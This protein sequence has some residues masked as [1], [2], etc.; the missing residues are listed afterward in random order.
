MNQMIRIPL[1][2][3]LLWAGSALAESA[4]FPFSFWK[5]SASP[6]PT[7]TATAT[8]TPTATATATSTPT[9]TATATATPTPTA[10]ATATATAT[11][12]ATPAVL[13]YVSDGDA[14]GVCYFIGTNFGA[15]SW[16]NP[17][18]A[19]RIT[20]VRSSDGA[21]SATDLVDHAAN[22]NSASDNEVGAWF[23][24]DLGNA[25]RSLVVNKY[26]LQNR[27]ATGE[28][29]RNWKLQG[30]NNPGSNS[31]SDLAAATWTDLDVHTADATI[32]AGD[33]WGTFTL[34][35]TPAA[36]RWFRI[37]QT[38][39]NSTGDNYLTIAEI[40]FYGTLNY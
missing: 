2:L 37:V 9:A 39:V 22:F 27:T 15:S 24:I 3:F 14:N 5:N 34:G 35:S 19:G 36:Y 30:S 6:T 17:F 31:I 28:Y 25:S 1:C 13:T 7:A 11:P 20:V 26:S 18:T 23:A 38:G 40:E 21:G 8:A 10:T 33:A 16:T 29:I 32:N 12:T 4:T